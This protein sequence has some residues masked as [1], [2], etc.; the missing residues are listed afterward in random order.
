MA[1]QRNSQRSLLLLMQSLHNSLSDFI[2][3]KAIYV[4]LHQCFPNCLPRLVCRCAAGFCKMLNVY[5]SFQP[6]LS[7]LMD[8]NL[9]DLVMF[10]KKC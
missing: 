1:N 6:K 5:T 3:K 10:P 4:Y 8:D 2:K 9:E 7:E